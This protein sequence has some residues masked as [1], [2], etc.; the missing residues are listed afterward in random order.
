MPIT[1]SQLITSLLAVV[2]FATVAVCPGYVAAWATDL[3]EFR[4][5]SLVERVFWAV[6]LSFALATIGSILVAR[7]TSLLVVAVALALCAVACT[8]L[9]LWETIDLHRRGERWRVGFWPLGWIAVALLALWM[10]V[11]II[12]LIDFQSGQQLYMNT[13]LLDESFRV[14][15]IESVLRTGVPPLNAQYLFGQTAP[16]HNYYFWYVV[17]ATVARLT[18]LPARGVMV[19]GSVWSGLLF[20]AVTGL[21]LKHF[22]RAGALLRRQFLRGFL[23]FYVTGLD[24]C[25]GIWMI[26]AMHSVPPPDMEAWSKD[27]VIS[28]LHT[29]LWAPHHL[30][31]LMLCMFAFLVAWLEGEER[32]PRPVFAIAICG[33]TL[34][35]AFGISVY[36]TFAF[37]LVM[38]LWAVW[39]LAVEHKPRS[40]WVLALGGAF[41]LFLLT[42]YFYELLHTTAASHGSGG[43]P[44]ALTVRQMIPP[45]S[46]AAAPWLQQIAHGHAWLADGLA[47][48]V[49]LVPG[50]ALEF[51]FYLAVLLIYLIPAW[52]GRTQLSPAHRSL[53]VIGLGALP[54]MSFL[55]SSV[56]S[57]NDFGW[58][59][60]LVLQYPL[61]LFGTEVVLGWSL[62]NKGQAGQLEA[63]QLPRRTPALVRA[64]AALALIC[65]LFGTV[66]QGLFLRFAVPIA[67]R[68]VK[69]PG[70]FATIEIPHNAYISEVGY[71]QLSR[72][73]ALDATVQFNPY[74]ANTYWV[75]T[76]MLGVNRQTAIA[77]DQPWCGSEMGGDPAGCTV[78]APVIDEV[79][80]G[81]TAER[82]QSVCR[83]FGINYLV[84]RI[85]DPAW[86]DPA[87]WVWHMPAVV[88]DPEFRALRCR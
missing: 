70:Q 27:G 37:F 45:E 18:G 72:S 46:L 65:G 3:H 77:S 44:F 17:C 57:V 63:S 24:L 4:R 33:A 53:L 56:L 88:A 36:V 60:A 11:A 41:S 82:A 8:A 13:A 42:P 34:A 58:R 5:R 79:Y 67:H 87:G 40:V 81:V 55:R 48:L 12:S 64:V 66:A 32:C 49:L 61:F 39:Q 74:H 20:F 23:L 25:V 85:Y 59:S 43:M 78:M 71:A 15:W 22:L 73:V 62:A 28:W 35:S 69:G 68:V 52:R 31:S 76:D 14:N 80:R 7:F 9:V 84:A 6:P 50:Y 75:A 21:L 10:A 47:R 83:Q 38:V 2:A 1:V 29:L 16:M 86:H 30:A 54:A 26:F 19:A 51:G